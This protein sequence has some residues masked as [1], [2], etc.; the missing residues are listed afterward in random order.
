METVTSTPTPAQQAAQPQAQ[1][2]CKDLEGDANK[3]PCETEAANFVD[4][5]YCSPPSAQKSRE[6]YATMVYNACNENLNK[7]EG[8]FSVDG[9]DMDL[10]GQVPNFFRKHPHIDYVCPVQWR[11]KILKDLKENFTQ[12]ATSIRAAKQPKL[13][14]DE[15]GATSEPTDTMATDEPSTPQKFAHKSQFN[16]NQS[17]VQ[18]LHDV[19]NRIWSA[20]RV[21]SDLASTQLVNRVNLGDIDEKEF[22]SV[23]KLR[24]NLGK[25]AS[26]A[27]DLSLQFRIVKKEEEPEE[28][29]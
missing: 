23:L 2:E 20:W 24:D 14:E 7:E 26:D 22:N 9:V 11:D 4:K 8:I 29:K 6:E 17:V 1:Q 15:F 10:A 13:T 3:Q 16:P 25:I 19:S 28:S 5:R 27:D 21:M 12:C 18:T